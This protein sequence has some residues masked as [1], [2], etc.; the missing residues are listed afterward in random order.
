M[1]FF[2]VD[3]GIQI[4]SVRTKTG[5][6]RGFVQ[7]PIV[8]DLDGNPAV[9]DV[10]IVCSAAKCYVETCGRAKNDGLDPCFHIRSSVE[11]LGKLQ[12]LVLKITRAL[13]YMPTTSYLCFASNILF[14]T[15]HSKNN[16][17]II[18]YSSNN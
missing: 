3:P 18:K 13:I 17:F 16:D 9:V 1:Y 8:Q 15:E 10:G 14:L 4:Y 6:T 2:H 11:A 5:D 12:N 7:L